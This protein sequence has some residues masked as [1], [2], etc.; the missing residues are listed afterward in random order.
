M[1][2]LDRV[3]EA[4]APVDQ[5]TADILKMDY[6]CSGCWHSLYCV[7][8]PGRKWVVR[9]GVCE[10]KTPGYASKY[11]VEKRVNE[12]LLELREVRQGYPELFRGE[13]GDLSV[14]EKID[15]LMSGG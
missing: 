4:L 1:S 5:H 7:H 9:C 3:P 11:W 15:S 13:E 8:A 10:E 2:R 14:E 6:V 12:S